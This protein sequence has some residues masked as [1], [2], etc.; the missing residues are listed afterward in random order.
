LWYNENPFWDGTLEKERE[1]ISCSGK[2]EVKKEDSQTVCLKKL[3]P[4]G[5]LE[6]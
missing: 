6:G 4:E 5:E 3:H 2:S 1:I